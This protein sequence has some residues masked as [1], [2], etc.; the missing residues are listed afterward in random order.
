MGHF[1]DLLEVADRVD[2]LEL[3]F[4]IAECILELSVYFGLLRY[5]EDGEYSFCYWG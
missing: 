3:V 2:H 4:L 1:H 5:S